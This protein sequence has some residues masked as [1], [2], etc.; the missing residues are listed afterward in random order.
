YWRAYHEW[1]EDWQFELTFA[2]RYRRFLTLEAIRFDSNAYIT[3]WTH[4]LGGA[5]YYE[6][7]R[8]N[9]L[10]WAESFMASFV[11]SAGYEYISEWREVISVNDMFL[12][13]FGGYTL[14]ETYFQITDYFHH[15]RSSALR[16][17]GFMNPFNE[18]NQW[19]DRKN[20]ASRT[21]LEPGWSSFVL[22]AGWWRSSETGRGSFDAGFVN[23]ETQIIRIPE[24]GKPG[25]LKKILRDTSLSELSM[26]TVVRQRRPGDVHLRTGLNEETDL[27]ARVVGL[28][29]YRQSLDELGRGT[30]FSIGLGS[31]M[32]YARKRNPIYDARGVPNH[33]APL[34]ETPTDFRDKMTVTHLVGPVVDWTWFGR[35]LKVRAVADA[36]VDFAMVNAFAFNAYSAV[37]PIVGMKATLNYY[38]YSYAYGGSASGRVDVDWGNLWVRGFISAHLWRSW[39][40][41]DRYENEITNNVNPVDSRTRF[42][43]QAG[44]RL[45]SAPVRALV[46]VEGLHRW[47]KIGD[48]SAGSQE[49]RTF[50]GLSYFF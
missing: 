32:T 14:G 26:N 42:L 4:V 25:T 33:M 38:G 27:Y 16:V 39:E 13:T 50:A 23:L 40:G 34:P 49:T 11:S 5:M 30:A 36:Y 10:T 19:L 46:G 29:W 3:N 22:S 7:A 8:S 47:G 12:T 28:S 44:W 31:A 41:L 24:Y 2:D 48:V 18:F 20:P 21:Y 35:R 6:F 17:L 43:I 1:V 15:R 37:H 45:G 9:Y